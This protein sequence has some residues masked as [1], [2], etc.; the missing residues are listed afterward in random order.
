MTLEPRSFRQSVIWKAAGTA[1][2][3]VIAAVERG[4]GIYG[5]RPSNRKPPNVGR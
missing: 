3:T 1:P 4:Y 5:G 2:L